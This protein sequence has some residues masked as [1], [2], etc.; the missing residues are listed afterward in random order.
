[1]PPT[2]IRQSALSTAEPCVFMA[3]EAIESDMTEQPVRFTVVLPE[4]SAA[5]EA[6]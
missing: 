6:D 2:V 4:K 5:W 1:M 3:S